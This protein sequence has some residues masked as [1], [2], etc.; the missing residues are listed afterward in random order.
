[1]SFTKYAIN[2]KRTAFFLC[3]LQEKFRPMISNFPQVLNTA[4]KMIKASQILE[5]PLIVTEHYSKALGKT[6]SEL[7]L[8]TAKVIEKTKFSMVVPQL[9]ADLDKFDSI[10]LF[11]IESHVCILQTALVM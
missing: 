7:D 10:V 1:M 2:P 8:L 6:C 3:D 4:N 11:G 9:V 5:I